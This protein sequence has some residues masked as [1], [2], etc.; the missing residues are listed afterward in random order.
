MTG[1]LQRIGRH[2]SSPGEPVHRVC[3]ARGGS[4]REAAGRGPA[5]GRCV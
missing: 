5:P 1:R 3:P 4:R 2:W